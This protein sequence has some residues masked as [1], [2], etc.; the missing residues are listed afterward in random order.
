MTSS[1]PPARPRVI[2]DFSASSLVDLISLEGRTA[3][4]TGG[5]R[6]IGRAI[7][8]RLAEAGAG[9]LIADLDEAEAVRAAAELDSQAAA[10][11]RGTGVDV[12]DSATVGAAA[13]L[14]IELGGGLD[15][16]VNAAGIYPIHSVLETDDAAWDRTLD[17]NLRGTFLGA[18]EAA[19]RMVGREPGGVILNIASTTGYLA[20]NPGIAHYV[21]SKHGVIGLTKSLAVEFGEHGVRA[22]AIA[23]GAVMTPGMRVLE[24]DFAA[25]VGG[26][27]IEMVTARVRLGRVAV[28]DDV[29]RVALFCVSDLAA[30][31]T[32]TTIAV[33]AGYLAS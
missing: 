14:A 8:G 7:A 19:R 30:Y 9:V 26:D 4:V 5:A 21:S 1:T 18:R 28:P 24:D 23:P 6:G 32:G 25:N 15:I 3:V 31:M 16:W 17:I 27:F 33:D 20:P 10:R 12:V 11:V 13:D 2:G 22:L 29:A